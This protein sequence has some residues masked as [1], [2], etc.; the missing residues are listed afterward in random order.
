ML[1]AWGSTRLRW[2]FAI[3]YSTVSRQGTLF[4]AL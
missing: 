3:S 1:S 2:R 4:L